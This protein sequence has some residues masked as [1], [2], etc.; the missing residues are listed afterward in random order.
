MSKIITKA[1]RQARDLEEARKKIE[2]DIP[3]RWEMLKNLVEAARLAIEDGFERRSPEEVE[4]VLK[5][6][7]ACPKLIPEQ[8]GGRCGACGCRLG[9]DKSLGKVSLTSWK[10][11]LGYWK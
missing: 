5:I 7:A 8:W 9:N 6:C 2:K 10:C 4:R 1:E 11:P 3:S